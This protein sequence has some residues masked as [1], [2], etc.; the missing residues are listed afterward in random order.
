MTHA[1]LGT[2]ARLQPGPGVG[3]VTSTHLSTCSRSC[4]GLCLILFCASTL[5]ISAAL[6]PL[7]VTMTSPGRRSPAAAFPCSVTSVEK[8]RWDGP[9]DPPPVQC[10]IPG[11]APAPQAHPAGMLP[12][13]GIS[14]APTEQ[15]QPLCQEGT[16]A[17]ETTPRNLAEPSPA[18]PSPGARGAPPAAITRPGPFPQS[19]IPQGQQTGSSPRSSPA[20]PAPQRPSP[21]RGTRG[22]LLPWRP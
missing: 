17:L 5:S 3:A 6:S 22:G 15:C 11:A 8:G 18:Q 10:S 19:R 20:R 14:R 9:G 16:T 12:P 4:P 13:A 2:P 1:W 21:A 7:M